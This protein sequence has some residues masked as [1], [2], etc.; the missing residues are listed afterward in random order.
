MMY[1]LLRAGPVEGEGFC[2]MGRAYD[3]SATGLRFELDQELRPGQAL[4]LRVLLP[5]RRRQIRLGAEGHVV[6]VHHPQLGNGR[7]CLALQFDRFKESE[8]QERL[9]RY[10]ARALGRRR[11][12][13]A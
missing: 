12:Q 3:I 10:V 5:G 9:A 4:N 2:W 7:T 13:A 11:L 6:R 1:T 8:H